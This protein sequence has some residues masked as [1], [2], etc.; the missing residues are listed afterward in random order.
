M[1]L[2]KGV[3]GKLGGSCRDLA[4]KSTSQVRVN[5]DLSKLSLECAGVG[6][7]TISLL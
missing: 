1:V 6:Q 2:E 5:E 3:D 4:V 7:G